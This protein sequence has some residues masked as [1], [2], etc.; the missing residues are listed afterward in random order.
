MYIFCLGFRRGLL[1]P[2]L[3]RAS[4]SPQLSASF[5]L[6]L[7]EQV[8]F[9]RPDAK[10]TKALLIGINYSHQ[11]RGQLRGSHNDVKTI[12]KFIIRCCFYNICL[13]I[14]SVH[15]RHASIHKL[16]LR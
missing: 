3:S 10:R 8:R 7:T 15:Y 13:I 14:S 9:K 6:P 12:K 11:D 2:S 1:T 16:T 5:D 4:Q